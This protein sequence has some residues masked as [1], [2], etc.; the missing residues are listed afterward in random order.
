MWRFVSSL[1]FGWVCTVPCGC[2]PRS[3]LLGQ[4]APPLHVELLDGTAI[5]L[6]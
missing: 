5:T 3:P 4:P 1:V 2:T 6:E